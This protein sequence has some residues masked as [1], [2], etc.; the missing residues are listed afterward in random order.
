MTAENENTKLFLS[1]ADL[2][3]S[4]PLLFMHEWFA[5]QLGKKTIRSKCFDFLI[6]FIFKVFFRAFLNFSGELIWNPNIFYF[7]QNQIF[8]IPIKILHCENRGFFEEKIQLRC[9]KTYL[10]AHLEVSRNLGLTL[11]TTKFDVF[12]YWNQVRYTH[13]VI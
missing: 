10:S 11:W 9:P 6:S 13:G 8:S 2:Q 7:L 12:L 4:Y 5:R 3:G 1:P